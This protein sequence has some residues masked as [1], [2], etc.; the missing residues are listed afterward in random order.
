LLEGDA[1]TAFLMQDGLRFGRF[2]MERDM[3]AG[4]PSDGAA[5]IAELARDLRRGT[6]ALAHGGDLSWAPGL[7]VP[8][9]F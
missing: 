7:Y 2:S 8:A 5:A 3:L 1:A 6:P 4:F 9:A